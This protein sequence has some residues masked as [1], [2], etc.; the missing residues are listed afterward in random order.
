VATRP[1]GYVLQHIHGRVW[2]GAAQP[3]VACSMVQLQQAAHLAS[4][5]RSLLRVCTYVNRLPPEAK[6]MTILICCN[7]PT[8][9]RNSRRQ[10]AAHADRQLDWGAGRMTGCAGRCLRSEG[11][12]GTRWCC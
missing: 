10:Q 11:T 12:K 3:L 5:S 2:G 8:A 6:S 4:G 7:Q 1:E 9:N